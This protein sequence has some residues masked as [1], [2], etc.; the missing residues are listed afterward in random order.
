MRFRMRHPQLRY[1]VEKGSITV[2]GISLTVAAR[3]RRRL[4][5]GG[6]P[7][8][9]YSGA[10]SARK[11]P[12]TRSTSKSTCS[13]STSSDCLRTTRPIPVTA[14]D[15][16][17]R[18][19]ANTSREKHAMTF[20]TSRTRSPRSAAAKSSSSSTTSDRERGRPHRG[21]GEDHR[22]DHGVHGPP[23]E[24]RHLH[25]D[26]RGAARR[27]EHPHGV[28]QHRRSQRTASTVSVDAKHET[29][30]GI[31]AAYRAT[32]GAHAGEPGVTVRRLRAARATSCC[33]T[34]KVVCSSGPATPRP[35]WTWPG[36]PV[37]CGGRAR[38]SRQ[39]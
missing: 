2:D 26:A 21:R 36:S 24:W 33:A 23:Y 17:F 6:H 25:A 1:I 8:P 20:T 7:R 27:V 35:W 19:R 3:A 29:T 28:E 12:V 5:R 34:A 37:C 13:R 31:S 9:R 10:T 32:H 11:R 39:R 38:R 16:T 4:R 14:G 30:T 18:P 15:R 22:G